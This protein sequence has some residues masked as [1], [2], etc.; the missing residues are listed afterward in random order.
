MKQKKSTKNQNPEAHRTFKWKCEN[1][2][3][4]HTLDAYIDTKYRPRRALCGI[5]SYAATKN[6]VETY[7]IANWAVRQWQHET[8]NGR[9]WQRIMTRVQS[10][11]KSTEHTSI[12][13]KTLLS[14]LGLN[15]TRRWHR[16]SENLLWIRA[17]HS[18][19]FTARRNT[20]GG[21][22]FVFFFF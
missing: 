7:T 11:N 8:E 19:S 14:P 1:C 4:T 12:E 13:H 16:V 6:K 3:A 2:V 20:F 22:S 21:S 10:A 17:A 5:V 15:D 9:K 18:N